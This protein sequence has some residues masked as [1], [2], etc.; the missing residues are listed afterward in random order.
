[1]CEAVRDL[2]NESIFD[3]ANFGKV[4]SKFFRDLMAIVL[5]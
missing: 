2:I 1:M 5:V 3:G 4:K